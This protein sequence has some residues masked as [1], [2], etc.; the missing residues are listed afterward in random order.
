MFLFAATALAGVVIGWPCQRL[1]WGWRNVWTT[2]SINGFAPSSTAETPA[3]IPTGFRTSNVVS[4]LSYLGA[5][6]V[7][8]PSGTPNVGV[9][10]FLCQQ[11]ALT[12]AGTTANLR[13]RCRR[14]V[15]AYGALVRQCIATP[16]QVAPGLRGPNALTPLGP[17]FGFD[18]M[19][20]VNTVPHVSNSQGLAFATQFC[21]TGAPFAPANLQSPSATCPG[22]LGWF[23][24]V[25]N[26][27]GFTNAPALAPVN[28]Q[29]PNQSPNTY[30]YFPLQGGVSSVLFS[31][32][33]VA[34]GAL[35]AGVF[36][37]PQVPS[38]TGTPAA[39]NNAG[40]IFRTS[41]C[42][43][44]LDQ[45]G[46]TAGRCHASSASTPAGPAQAGGFSDPLRLLAIGTPV[47]SPNGLT[48][49]VPY[50]N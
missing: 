5:N 38:A 20:T 30:A 34:V 6:G 42:R 50:C 25:Y 11:A 27:C 33:G 48:Q 43:K 37:A 31:H 21:A 32:T 40:P 49:L 19:P 16:A 14:A 2:C 4:P 41:R 18:S 10:A 24:V 45:F 35:N 39:W 23:T 1:N 9:P 3:N 44:A 36:C 47:G 22:L 7:F 13:N 15:D 28:N 8:A 26:T 46:R 12:G 29:V 17:A